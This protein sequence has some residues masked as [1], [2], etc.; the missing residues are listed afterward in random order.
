MLVLAW[1]GLSHAA[2]ISA[3]KGMLLS[4]SP[5]HGNTWPN[6]FQKMRG[7]PSVS[8]FCLWLAETPAPVAMQGHVMP[9]HWE[10]PAGEETQKEP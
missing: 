7:S 2:I 10:E 6:P 9:G 4:S 1:I 5:A 3:L 8:N